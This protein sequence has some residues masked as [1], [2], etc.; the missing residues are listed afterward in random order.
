M[1]QR[2][3]G[4][5]IRWNEDKGYG[6]IAPDVGGPEV[7]VHVAEF[8]RDQRRPRLG[9]RVGFVVVS[10]SANRKK[11][12]ELDNI[13]AYQREVEATLPHAP[14]GLH[15]PRPRRLPWWLLIPAV[16]VVALLGWQHFQGRASSVSA[17]ASP[18][19]SEGER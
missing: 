6:F 5:L 2:Q 10:E 19:V 14:R 3:E 17:P 11:A 1:S 15:K 4:R 12:V 9:D 7:F 8:S 18:P 16:V 13:S